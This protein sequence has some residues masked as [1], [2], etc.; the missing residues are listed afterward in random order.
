MQ[1]QESLFIEHSK[2]VVHQAHVAPLLT[3]QFQSEKFI[4]S[5]TGA[6]IGWPFNRKESHISA[7]LVA[8]K[9][10]VRKLAAMV[11]CYIV[12]L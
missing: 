2:Y 10:S 12:Q 7:T 5:F 1:I 9:L 6:I 3:F 11:D 4:V 8:S